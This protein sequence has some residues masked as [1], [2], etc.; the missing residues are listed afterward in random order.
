[1]DLCGRSSK[2]EVMNYQGSPGPLLPP[3]VLQA[4][5]TLHYFLGDPLPLV[6]DN[7]TA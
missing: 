3:H 5:I 4:H 1:M 7:G 2:V 6:M